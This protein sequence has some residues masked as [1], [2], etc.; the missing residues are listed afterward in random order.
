MPRK[1][2]LARARTGVFQIRVLPAELRAWRARAKALGVS[3]AA[4]LR[5]LANAD[6]AAA[7]AAPA[8]PR[9]AKGG[10]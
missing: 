1:P 4:H 6:L 7:P 5:N 2:D 8:A 10:R 9:D 3:L